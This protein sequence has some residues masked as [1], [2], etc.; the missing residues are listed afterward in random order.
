MGANLGDY[1]PQWRLV[2]TILNPK[3]VHGSTASLTLMNGV[4]EL[5][6]RVGLDAKESSPLADLLGAKGASPDALNFT[7]RD[8]ML[9]IG[10]NLNDGEKRW[11]KLMDLMDAL[12]KPRRGEPERPAP[13]EVLK[14]AQDR[15]Q[16]SVAKD[17][18]GRLTSAAVVVEP[19]AALTSHGRPVPLVVLQANDADAAKHLEGEGL[20]KLIGLAAVLG[21][22]PGQA[23]A[24]VR[25]DVDGRSIEV[26]AAGA[27]AD[28]LG[29]KNLYI[30]REG[31][32]VV[33]GPDKT[34]VVAALNAGAKKAGLLGD[35][36]AAAAIKDVVDSQALAVVSVGKGVVEWFRRRELAPVTTPFAP[37]APNPPPGPGDKP[38]ADQPPR[39]SKRAEQTIADVQ[40]VVGPLPPTVV[41]LKRE[42]EALTLEA[43]QAGLKG[44]TNKLIDLWIESGMDRIVEAMKGAGN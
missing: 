30:G 33:V 44:V 34:E 16:L 17:V 42:P 27:F 14:A 4:V 23:P 25:E 1:E 11:Q 26:V 20:P 32:F 12:D 19:T 21:G 5:K 35:E 8:G 6:A 40:K 38:P 18:L 39:L 2:K 36:K 9:T 7:P 15:I 3:A 24:P 43:R 13:S 22:A 28:L 10:L 31:A 41:S 29:A 37:V